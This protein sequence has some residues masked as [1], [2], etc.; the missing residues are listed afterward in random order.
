M[1]IVLSDLGKH[2][3]LA[4]VMVVLDTS[5]SVKHT[6]FLIDRALESLSPIGKR[7]GRSLLI[8]LAC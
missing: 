6:S 7:K 5:G 8:L 4:R 2:F 3:I 1:L